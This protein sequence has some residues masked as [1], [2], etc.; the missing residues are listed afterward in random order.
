MFCSA[1]VSFAKSIMKASGQSR[2]QGFGAT[3]LMP[4]VLGEWSGLDLRVPPVPVA[5]LKI[6]I[7]KITCLKSRFVMPLSVVS[8]DLLCRNKTL[9]TQLGAIFKYISFMNRT[10]TKIAHVFHI[11]LGGPIGSPC[12][13]PPLVAKGMLDL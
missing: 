2:Q 8:R 13:Y 5:S 3:D 7:T 6:L 4:G 11:F 9:L 1:F 12:C 10:N